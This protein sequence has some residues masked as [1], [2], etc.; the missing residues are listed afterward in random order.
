MQIVSSKI[1][2]QHHAYQRRARRL[3]QSEKDHG[4]VSAKTGG[5]RLI[6]RLLEAD[7]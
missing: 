2:A 1:T 7:L 5:Q 4:A 3:G 6:W